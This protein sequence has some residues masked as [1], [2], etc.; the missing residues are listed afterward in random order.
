MSVRAEH[1]LFLRGGLVGSRV[2]AVG[3]N[4]EKAFTRQLGEP[5]G[6]GGYH[7]RVLDIHRRI[8]RSTSHHDANT[9]SGR[10]GL[11]YCVARVPV[12]RSAPVAAL[13]DLR[14]TDMH[15]QQ[16]LYKVHFS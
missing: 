2:C 3:R 13:L 15:T 9:S 5:A 4:K 14:E 10:R 12:Q 16:N 11:T 6:L 7:L 1:N 8:V